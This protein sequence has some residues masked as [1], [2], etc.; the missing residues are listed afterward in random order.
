[1]VHGL[2]SLKCLRGHTL[3]IGYDSNEC[4]C[5]HEGKSCLII[6]CKECLKNKIEKGEKEFDDIIIPLDYEGKGIIEHLLKK[7]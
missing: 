2:V 1:M 3:P 7:E 6:I 5:H 4:S